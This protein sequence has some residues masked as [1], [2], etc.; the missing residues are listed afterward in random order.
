MVIYSH[1][2]CGYVYDPEKKGIYRNHK[3]LNSYV[4]IWNAYVWP[5]NFYNTLPNIVSNYMYHDIEFITGG[6]C[7]TSRSYCACI[8][9]RI[10][11]LRHEKHF[12]LLQ[13]NIPQRGFGNGIIMWNQISSNHV[14]VWQT[15]NI[16]LLTSVFK[17]WQVVDCVFC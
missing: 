15:M 16:V 6:F 14:Y 1:F 9:L 7:I 17:R 4:E 11:F 8:K 5:W 2:I 10:H 3:T 13:V 12:N